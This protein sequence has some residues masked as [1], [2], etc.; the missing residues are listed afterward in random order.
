MA[1]RESVAERRTTSKSDDPSTISSRLS[2]WY[3]NLQI[4]TLGYSDSRQRFDPP[5]QIDLAESHLR[6]LRAARLH[7]DEFHVSHLHK[8]RSPTEQARAGAGVVRVE[9][10]SHLFGFVDFLYQNKILQED[11]TIDSSVTQRKIQKCAYIAQQLGIPFEYKFGFLAS[12][13]FSVDMAVDLYRRRLATTNQNLFDVRDMALQA[14][15][16]IV[17][18]KSSDWLHVATFALRKTGTIL[19]SHDF[20][21]YMERRNPRYG[22]RLTKDVFEHV[23]HLRQVVG[24]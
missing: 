2:D 10:I 17:R 14:F 15:L 8:L 9:R 12:G 23:Q 21:K 1:L 20:V 18:D 4:R 5:A 7:R 16:D 13:A 11:E 24:Q 22:K 3:E 19:S 6:A